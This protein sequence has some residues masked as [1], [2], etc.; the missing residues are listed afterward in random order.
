MTINKT[1]ITGKIELPDAILTVTGAGNDWT[2]VKVENV[3]AEAVRDNSGKTIGYTWKSGDKAAVI[4]GLK[5]GTY[6][7]TEEGEEFEHGGA[8]YTTV[9]SKTTFTV[10]N[11]KLTAVMGDD[12]KSSA[13]ENAT[14]SYVIAGTDTNTITVCDA[15]KPVVITADVTVNK[16]DITGEKEIE[17]ANLE[18]TNSKID[19]TDIAAA[20]QA[21]LPV[22]NGGDTIIGLSWTS[23]AE[24]VTVNGLPEGVYTLRETNDKPFEYDGATYEVIDSEITFKID[25]EGKVSM[26]KAPKPTN[27]NVPEQS[28][29]GYAMISGKT[30]TICDASRTDIILSKKDI[31]NEK[32]V[33]GATLIVTDSDGNTVD[34]WVSDGSDHAI[35]GL[36]NGTYTLT[37]TA[38]DAETAGA[39][40]KIVDTTVT[41][42]VKNGKLTSVVA[43]NNAL[44]ASAEEGSPDGFVLADKDN[45]K[46]TVCDAEKTTKVVIKKTDIAGSEELTGA[47]LT[48]KDSKGKTITGTPWTSG[49]D[50]KELELDLTDGTYTLTETQG[51]DKIVDTEGNEYEVIDSTLTFKVEGG[52]VTEVTNT[53]DKTSGEGFYD[54]DSDTNTIT[55]ND[56]KKIVTTKVVIKKT[57]IAG[58]EELTGAVLTVKDSDGNTITGT[59]WTSGKD[60]KELVLDLTDG[61]YT[62]TET[63]GDDKIVDT[64]GNEYEVIDS[65]LTFK[66][67]GGKVTEVTNTTDKTSGEGFYDVDSDTN[68]ITVNDAKKVVTTKVVIKKTDIAGSEELTGAV[69]TVK[70]SK[71]KT[72]TGT[73][74]TS[75]KD[76]KEL[77]LDLTDG[78]Y[79]LTETQG[80][81]KI[82]DTEG[83]EYEVIDSTLTFKVEGGKVTEVTNTTSKDSGEG[84]YDVDSDTNTITVN[85]AKKVVTTKVVIKKTDIAGSEELTGAVLTVKD[86]DGNT[87][88]GTPWTSG[89]DG[90]ELVLDLTDGTYTLTETQGDDK[91]VDTE[92]NEYE[93]IDSTLTFKV[94][95]G[96]VTEVTNTTDKT[97]GEGFYD[98]DSDT[99]TITVND[100]KKT[101]K[102]VI[103]KTDIAGSEELTGAVLTVKDSDSNTITGTPWTSGK[104]GKELVLD[105]TDG[106]YTLTETQGD[107]KIVDTEG[108]EY[109][110]IDSTL[111]FKVE[112][113]KVTEV[114]NTT[115]KDSGEGFYDVDSDTNTIT[116][117]DAKRVIEDSSSQPEDESSSKP[118]EDS[119]S[120]PD[121]DSSS[122][123]DDTSS[124][125]EDDSSRNPHTGDD[126]NSALTSE[127]ESS[128]RPHTGEDSGSGLT[129]GDDRSRKGETDS[130]S[131]A[132]KN[133]SNSSNGSSASKADSKSG[134]TTSTAT[135]T[136][137]GNP[138]TGARVLVNAAEFAAAVG[139]CFLAIKRRKNDEDDQ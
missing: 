52:K 134:A 106:T 49:K 8:T 26:T 89:K 108:N 36:T 105:L 79:T 19:W 63:Q 1:D 51:D 62:L 90:K 88:T 15:V 114:T 96:K 91:I 73:P 40:Y 77:V 44:A 104:D 70:D 57:D 18:I 17:G 47:V 71:G 116:V 126:S 9:T 130:G 82:V 133:D 65:T 118:D 107:D 31:R 50:G 80:D 53:T 3:K 76:G 46:I 60:G 119:S 2:N 56:A 4:K 85:D 101:T 12:V 139:L 125:T 75:G 14:E 7:L 113:G 48:V 33:L 11:G 23:G 84:F 97:S 137:T 34:E 69:L 121:E 112:G 94:E 93:V 72:I 81:D 100:A 117:N 87:I 78:T 123:P 132:D 99:N 103:K 67:E 58:S 59:P 92:G 42:T 16:T 111:T 10:K 83:N 109:E 20:N 45:N 6:T 54:V 115:S 28:D 35:K 39:E 64:E 66:V 120:K 138:N 61:T 32:E 136:G 21:L 25:A 127:E 128:R 95:G 29:K 86:S 74:W 22:R 98:V 102:V 131:V 135:G 13:N 129:S 30:I 43:D 38:V 27:E 5:N 41:F 68:T 55:V 24:A 110:V 124:E 37:E 122:K